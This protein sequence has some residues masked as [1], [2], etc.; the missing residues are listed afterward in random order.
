MPET[1]QFSMCWTTSH[2][3][4]GGKQ[5]TPSNSF[6]TERKSQP[7]TFPGPAS[8]MQADVVALDINREARSRK[9]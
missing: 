1:R 9:G 2:F 4:V 6:S 8:L 3:R 5:S 7:N